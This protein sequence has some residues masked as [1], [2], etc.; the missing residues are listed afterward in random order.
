MAEARGNSTY[1]FNPHY[2]TRINPGA[3][4]TLKRVHQPVNQSALYGSLDSVTKLLRL[5][6]YVDQ[7]NYDDIV[8]GFNSGASNTYDFNED[9]KY[10]P[11]L[12]SGEGL[13]SYSSDGVP[14]SINLLPLP[15]QQVVIRLDVEAKNSGQILLE[16]TQLDQ[17]PGTYSVW[18][19]DHYLKDSLDLRANA[20]Y[21]FSINKADTASFG[22]YRFCVVVRQSQTP[23]PPFQLTD[24]NASKSGAEAEISWDA[25]NEANN[26]MFTVERSEDGGTTFR[27]LDTLR[28]TSA[29]RYNYTDQTPPISADQYRLKIVSQSGTV[30]FSNMVMLQFANS[31]NTITQNINIYPN[32][33]SNVVNLAIHR[34]GANSVIDPVSTQNK[35]TTMAQATIT[36]NEAAVY[37]IKIVNISGA[38]IKMATAATDTWQQ[39]I[40]N[41]LPGTYIITVTN[42]SN[43]K[44]IGRSSF[45]KM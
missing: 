26:T 11:G 30:S 10:M 38:V 2:H 23:V 34:A 12:G 45:V 37:N 35:I 1:I 5:K 15:V 19:I 14:L 33:A 6:L 36:A 40:T 20:N 28:S 39:N 24:F 42:N 22:S 29:G 25:K 44:L 7:Y 9:A 41:L 13:S 17:L 3:I 4:N 32:P 16:K 21:I 31:I 43:N 27:I 8:I 18:L